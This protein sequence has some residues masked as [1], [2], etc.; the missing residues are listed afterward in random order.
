MQPRMVSLSDGV[1]LAIQ[2]SMQSG[3]IVAAT[4]WLGC[5]AN[6]FRGARVHGSYVEVPLRS[7]GRRDVGCK[8]GRT[9]Y[10]GKKVKIF[11]VE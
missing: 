11:T 10:R 5:P 3:N 2:A 1:G 7:S 9:K 6:L 4:P 8:G